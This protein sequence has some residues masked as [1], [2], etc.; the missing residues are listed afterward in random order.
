[1]PNYVRKFPTDTPTGTPTQA[2]GDARYLLLD[3]TTPQYI[4]D[5]SPVVLAEPTFT[6]TSG[7]LTRIDY[8]SGYYK[9][10]SYNLDGTLNEIDFNGD[11]EKSF[12]YTDGLLT[13]IEVS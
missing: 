13:K 8:P 1:M 9:I 11:Y 6:Y 5:G 2:E 4:E 10:L 12:S 7:V 3:Q